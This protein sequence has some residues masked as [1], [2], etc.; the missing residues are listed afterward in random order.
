MRNRLLTICIA[1]F[2]LATGA[3]AQRFE[4]FG[5]YSYLRYNPTINGLNTRSLN[6]GGGGVQLNFL[7]FLA[8]KGD[9]QGYMST[10]TEV[11]VTSPISTPKGIIPVGLYKSN[12]SMFSYLFGPVVRIPGKHIRPFGE[13]L[14]GGVHTNL[15]AQLNNSLIAQ[16]G[17]IDTSATAQH[18]F[19][20]AFGG[21]LDV[22]VNKHFALRLGEV[23]WMLTR[24]T[25]VWTNTNNQNNFRY[26]GGAVFTFGD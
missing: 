12:A 9:F 7:K 19:A 18:P 23:D 25:N 20:M 8:L 15:Y 11:N 16:G 13:L 6:G 17:K 22:V 5:D 26:L 14:F 21:G 24:F 10:Q 4:A 2:A 3:F 1:T